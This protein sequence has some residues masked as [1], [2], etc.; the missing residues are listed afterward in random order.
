MCCRQFVNA[1][2]MALDINERLIKEDQ[3]EY[4]EGLK[5]N[6]KSMVKELS[7]II[8]EPV[9]LIAHFHLYNSCGTKFLF[10]YLLLLHNTFLQL[11]QP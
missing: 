10:I 11:I 9:C 1:C 8:H 4:H 3:Y 5:A 6:F 7:E 2:S